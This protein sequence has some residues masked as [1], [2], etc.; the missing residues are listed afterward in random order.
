[1]SLYELVYVEAVR[2]SFQWNFTSSMKG[3]TS[4]LAQSQFRTY[5]KLY[6]RFLH[7]QKFRLVI[8]STRCVIFNSFK[9]CLHFVGCLQTASADPDQTPHNHGS[10]GLG[11]ELV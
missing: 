3:H 11:Y 6:S 9:P 4:G 7:F 5:H 10:V 1:M 2:K 8:S